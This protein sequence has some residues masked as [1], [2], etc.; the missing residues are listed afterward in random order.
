MLK[1]FINK[2][3]TPSITY[4]SRIELG[5]YIA[6]DRLYVLVPTPPFDTSSFVA[7]HDLKSFFRE[8]TKVL[9]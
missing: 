6:P 1:N 5:A 4:Y 2:R 7:T 3:M 8:L 9:T